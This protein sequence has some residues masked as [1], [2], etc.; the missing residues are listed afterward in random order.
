MCRIVVISGRALNDLKR[1]IHFK[2]VVCIGNHGFEIDGGDLKFNSLV[3]PKVRKAFEIVKSHIALLSADT[4]V[5]FVEDKGATLSIHYRLLEEKRVGPFR[6]AVQKIIRPYLRSKEIK[7][8]EG[9]KV[10]EL[11]PPIVW[12]KGEAVKWLLTQHAFNAPLQNALPIYIGDDTT[13]EDAFASLQKNGITI[14]IGIRPGS[15]ARYF[16]N[17]TEAVSQFLSKLLAAI[18]EK[19]TC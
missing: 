8:V 17:D 12:D 6:K 15:H 16:L 19:V 7:C 10:F 5:I 9:K 13:D 14:S 3:A 4:K 1:R 18:R 11:R 2:N